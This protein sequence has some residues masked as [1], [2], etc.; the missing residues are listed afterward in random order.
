MHVE[1]GVLTAALTIAGSDSGGNAGVQADIR[2]FHV[3]GLH[4]CTVFCALTAQNPS[5]V[6]AVA[7]QTPEFVEAQ[8]DAVL[9]AYAIK[10]AKTGML[11][12]PGVV[13]A[14]AAKMKARPDVPLVVDPVM[15]ATSGARLISESAVA[16]VR[17]VLLP[18]AA[19]ATPNLPEAETLCGRALRSLDDMAAAARAIRGAAGCAVL[20]K[21]GH[22]RGGEAE[23]VLACAEGE[24]LYTTPVVENPASVHGTGCSLS[25]AIAASLAL[26]RALPDA[27]REAKAYVYE[28]IRTSL[29]VGPAAAVL[30]TPESEGLLNHP[31]VSVSRLGQSAGRAV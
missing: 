17:D 10:A 29:P 21:G 12:D 19:V 28:A 14:V 1:N 9:P 16:A 22:R 20:V 15:V 23:D 5:G 31:C 6:S 3:F 8:L 30:G 7:G 25:A 24:F 18:V 2:A 26:G 4:A 27:V 11:A 13:R